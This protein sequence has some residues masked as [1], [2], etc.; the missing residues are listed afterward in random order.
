MQGSPGPTPGGDSALFRL[1]AVDHQRQ[2]FHGTVVL[3]RPW[4]FAAITALLTLLVF[5]LLVFAWK[6]GFTRKEVVTGIVVPDR[7]L[8]RLVAPQSGRV[9]EV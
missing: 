5:A 3:A 9:Q 6:A 1:E 7:G 4:S 2:R 8:I